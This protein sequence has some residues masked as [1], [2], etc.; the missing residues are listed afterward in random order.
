MNQYRRYLG[1]LRRPSTLDLCP[2]EAPSK[3]SKLPLQ[4]SAAPIHARGGMCFE[5]FE[6]AR[7]RRFRGNGISHQV[8]GH[9]EFSSI[10]M[11]HPAILPRRALPW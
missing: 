5:G 3:P 9:D 10:R 11:P 7:T 6:S 1:L 2:G 8:Y 4:V